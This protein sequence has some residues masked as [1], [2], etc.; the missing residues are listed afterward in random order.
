MRNFRGVRNF[1]REW[2]TR[3]K[4]R[5]RAVEKVRRAKFSML[6][7]KFRTDD[8]IQ[9]GPS[10]GSALPQRVCNRLLCVAGAP[11]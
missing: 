11:V 4:F 7:A 9:V 1:A 10:A 2:S 5:T 8:S 6:R 3:A